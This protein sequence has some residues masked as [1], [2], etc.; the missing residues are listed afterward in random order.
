MGS[1]SYEKL[2]EIVRQKTILKYLKLTAVRSHES[3]ISFC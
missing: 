3:V 1:G 2:L